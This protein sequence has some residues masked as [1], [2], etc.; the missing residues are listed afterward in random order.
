VAA[1]GAA[2]A[3]AQRCD[4]VCRAG[5]EDAAGGLAVTTVSFVFYYFQID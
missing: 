3:A 5:E 1:S 2:T 4:G